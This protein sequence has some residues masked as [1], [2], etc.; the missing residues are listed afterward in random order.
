V[1][2]PLRTYAFKAYSLLLPNLGVIG[3]PESPGEMDALLTG[4]V[5]PV[6]THGNP[7][8]ITVVPGVVGARAA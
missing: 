7:M 5:Q 8:R 4:L 3:M 6:R 2:T 1:R